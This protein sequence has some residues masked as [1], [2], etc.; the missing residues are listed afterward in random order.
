MFPEQTRPPSPSARPFLSIVI[1]SFSAGALDTTLTALFGQQRVQDFE[2]VLYDDA[3]SDGA[4]EIANAWLERYPSAI[5]LSRSGLPIGR[6]A[7]DLRAEFLCCGKIILR[8]AEER[9]FDAEAIA[10]QFARLKQGDSSQ[11]SAL[12]P[13]TECNPVLQLC[14]IRNILPPDM[15]TDQPLVSICIH[16]FNYGRYLRQ[17]LE[18]ALAQTWPKIE[19]CFSDNASDDDSWAIVNE[20]AKAHP[21]KIH[22]TRNRLDFGRKINFNNCISQAR[23]KYLL[24][25]CSDD[26]LAPEYIARCVNALESHPQAG[27]A[28]VHRGI[29]DEEGRSRHEP[30]F[31]D[32]SCVIPG[33]SQAAV[34]MMA[35]VNPS[36]S[37]ILYHTAK[38][39][40]NMPVCL[41]NEHWHG[42][43]MINFALCA[44]NAMIYIKDELVFHRIH[45]QSDGTKINN[46]LLQCATQYVMIHQLAELAESSGLSEAAARLPKAIDK[47]GQLCLRY[48]LRFL[49]Q[50]DFVCAKRYFHL[51]Q[52]ISP[53]IIHMP[54]F[55]SLEK[56]WSASVGEQD[57]ILQELTAHANLVSRTVSYPPPSDSISLGNA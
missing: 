57:S 7:T 8:L 4:W 21:G 39:L 31:Y 53:E 3:S 51:A 33:S 11:L 44:D 20:L 40:H 9:I 28:M 49:Q 36:I 12:R 42:S 41:L 37:Q 55:Q 15:D 50:N 13:A 19:I 29:L 25:L 30:P 46:N 2:V 16:N 26:A 1:A 56:Y 22:L 43:H 38:Y 54:Q 18:S 48:S 24:I 47:V 6:H 35:M 14:R 27:F 23:G 34:Y 52:A 17:C 32:R 10:V 45:T 5:T